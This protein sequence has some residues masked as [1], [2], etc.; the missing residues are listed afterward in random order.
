MSQPDAVLAVSVVSH[1]HGPLV[2][3]L[4]WQLAQHSHATVARVVLTLNI[5]EPEPAPPPKGWPFALH[6]LRN[7]QPAG[8][9]NNHNRAL[10]TVS[11]PFVCILNPDVALHPPDPFAVLVHT[12]AQPGTGCAYPMQVDAQG[13]VQD[14]ERA[15][16]TPTALWQRRIL[17]QRE[18]RTDWVNGACMVLP[19]AVWHQL[20]GF[21]NRY[22]IYCEDVDLCL[23]LRLAGLSLVRAPVSVIHTGQRA[24]Q[25]HWRHTLWH[26]CSLL[27]LW[28][29]SSYKAI[30]RNPDAPNTGTIA[31][32]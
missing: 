6:I 5:P 21:D 3:S 22:F 8:F 31:P 12:A 16:P 15:L 19:T 18:Q 29:S 4:L 10:Q 11:E 32:L 14:S 24:S 2:Q 23:R 1:G 7:T 17:G 28:S 20:G 25:R 27:R 26:V 9:G 13:Q 30:R